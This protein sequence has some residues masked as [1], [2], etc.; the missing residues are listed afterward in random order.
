M[1]SFSPDEIPAQLHASFGLVW[2]GETINGCSGTL[3]EYTRINNPHKLSLY[4]AAGIPVIVWAEAAVAEF[5]RKNH[6]GL[7]LDSISDLKD[8]FDRLSEDE[9]E[10]MRNHVKTM[11]QKLVSGFYLREVLKQIEKEM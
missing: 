8:V 11:Q 7:T 3:G 5:V 9:Y 1:G 10:D 4:I 2:D 6:L